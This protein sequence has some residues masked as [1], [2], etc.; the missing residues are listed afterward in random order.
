[1]IDNSIVEEII[2]VSNCYEVIKDFI[3]LKKSGT[4]WMGL[5]PFNDEKS[6][7]FMVSPVKN[8][9]KDF[10]SGQGGN[11][12]S[13][14]MKARGMNFPEAIKYLGAKYTIEIVSDKSFNARNDGFAKDKKAQLSALSFAKDH[15]YDNMK[16]SKVTKDYLI[17]RGFTPQIVKK[18]SLG[19][20]ED[21]W[22]ELLNKALDKKHSHNS[23]EKSDLISNKGR[24]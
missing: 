24:K 19:Y 6:P 15:F 21:S 2:E 14:L 16:K 8:I 3:E 22:N 13:F 18:F 11:A 17:N 4:N 20:S 5:S 12:I 10:S 7:S 1:M 23:L 9:W